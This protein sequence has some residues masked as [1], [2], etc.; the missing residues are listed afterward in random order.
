MNHPTTTVDVDTERFETCPVSGDSFDATD[1]DAYQT[2]VLGTAGIEQ[3][4]KVSADIA[5]ADV[6]DEL[7][8]VDGDLDVA[9]GDD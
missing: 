8:L 2:V 1:P 9:G 4:I 3:G 5:F 7:Q 6:L